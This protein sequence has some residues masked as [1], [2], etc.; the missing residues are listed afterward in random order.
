MSNDP[1]III[2]TTHT[3]TRTENKM[4]LISPGISSFPNKTNRNHCKVL[5]VILF[6][7]RPLENVSLL[8]TRHEL[9][10]GYHKFQPLLGAQGLSYS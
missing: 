9:Q 7:L 6:V 10:V 4:A 5:G 8:L 2:D 3:P 1:T